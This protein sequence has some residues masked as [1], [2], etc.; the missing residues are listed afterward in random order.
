MVDPQLNPNLNTLGYNQQNSNQNSPSK[1]ANNKTLQPLDNK[2]FNSSNNQ[3]AYK[4]YLENNDQQNT[5]ANQ[6]QFSTIQAANQ[7]NDQK[8]SKQKKAHM[9]SLTSQKGNENEPVPTGAG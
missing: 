5:S 9:R 6:K 2:D 8:V 7:L 3:N 4:Q 1:I